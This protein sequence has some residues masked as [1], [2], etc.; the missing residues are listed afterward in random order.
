MDVRSATATVRLPLTLNADLM[1][2]TVAMPHGW[3]HQHATGLS[4]ASKTSGVNVNLLATDGP[5]ALERVAGMAHLTG[6]P[7]TVHAAA[8]PQDP[9]S[10]SGISPVAGIPAR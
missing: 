9:R 6:I 10:W 8:G 4:H 7:V 3:G 5:E 1:P 2:G